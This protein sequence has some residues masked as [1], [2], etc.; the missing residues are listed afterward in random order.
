MLSDE[1][2]RGTVLAVDDDIDILR[3]LNRY[4]AA[5]LPTFNLITAESGAGA[6]Q[7][8]TNNPD[9]ILLDVNLPDT[10]GFSLAER[11]RAITSVPII[12]L[13]AR[14]TDEDKVRG[15][16]AGGDDYVTKPF[17][18]AELGARIKAHFRRESQPQK[19]ARMAIFD[20]ILIDYRAKQVS[21]GDQ[22]L[23]LE[24]KQYQLVELLSLNPGQVFSR[25][26]LY[27]K[28]WGYDALGDDRVITEHIR[29]IRLLF[30][31]Y[32]V[33]SPIETVWGVGYKWTS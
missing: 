21:I 8:L 25:E 27:E 29:R 30:D 2:L 4:F 3:M 1:R 31:R 7:R 15:L 17:S 22:V 20:Q 24:K 19:R 14:V 26:Q 18:L 12:F 11:I 5:R 10:D 28:I 32:Q 6:L 16:G 9:L 13:T 33:T 23:S